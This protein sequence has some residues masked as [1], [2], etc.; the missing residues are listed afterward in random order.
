MTMENQNSEQKKENEGE[1]KVAMATPVQQPD[2]SVI[3]DIPSEPTPK[4]CKASDCLSARRHGS[5]YCG[6][7]DHKKTNL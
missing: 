4:K 6:K 5:A 2:G 1:I 7:T 3:W